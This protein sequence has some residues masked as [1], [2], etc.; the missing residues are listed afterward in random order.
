MHDADLL[1]LLE[2]LLSL[3]TAPFHER[4]VSAFLRDELTRC[5]IDFTCD[6]YGNIITSPGG[7]PAL[8]LVAHMDHPGF[9]IADAGAKTAGAAWHGGVDAKYFRGARVVVYDQET[10]AIAARGTVRR[11]RKNAAGR[12]ETMT[13]GLNGWVRAGDFGTWD[14]VPFRRRGG[15]VRTKGADDLV[16]CATV[17]STLK[18]LKARGLESGL[19]GVFTRGEEQGF[20]GTLGMIRSGA[21]PPTVKIISVET[22]KALPGVVLGG[23]PV[24]RLGDRA[25]M[26]DHRMVYFMDAMARDLR[27]KERRFRSQRRVMDG[28]T[29]EATPYQLAGHIVGG[30]AIPLHNY[31]NQGKSRIGAEAV[32][33]RD[34]ENAVELLTELS[35]RIGEFN[36]ST[37]EVKSRI[38]SG[39]EKYGERLRGH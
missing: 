38:E 21:L 1:G 9:E 26:F 2:K 27:R 39:W 19:L 17:L 15:L 18:R 32:A 29:C 16:G 5:G 34:V 22:S 36:Q 13:L 8:A 33:V 12:V 37:A 30:V 28:G 3:P 31:H 6:Q 24:I 7:A 11:I 25:S 10:G 4:F 14:L 23:G 35:A 20:L